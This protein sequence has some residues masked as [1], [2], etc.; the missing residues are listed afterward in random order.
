MSLDL[1]LFFT[2]FRGATPVPKL[3]SLWLKELLWIDPCRGGKS[4]RDD[5]SSGRTR[6]E[7]MGKLHS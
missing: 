6:D 7:R 5:V 3:M 2:H 4:Y 1:S